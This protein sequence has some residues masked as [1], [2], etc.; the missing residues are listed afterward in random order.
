[1]ASFCLALAL[2]TPAVWLLAGLPRLPLPGRRSHRCPCVADEVAEVLKVAADLQRLQREL[3]D[4]HASDCRR[5][6]LHV[7]VTAVAAAYDETL[8]RGGR[9]LHLP[10]PVERAPIPPVER[11]LLEAQL[12]GAG[13]RW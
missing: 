10:V 4:L 12:T 7:R 13:I 6:G 3:S 2:V 1:M 11:V 5:P 9:V 8:L